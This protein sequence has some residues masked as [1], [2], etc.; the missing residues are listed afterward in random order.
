MTETYLVYHVSW[1]QVHPGSGGGSTGRVH[2]YVKTDFDAGRLKR[3]A[4]TPICNTKGGEFYPRD[5][6]ERGNTSDDMCRTC[7]ERATKYGLTY[8]PL[9]EPD[10]RPTCRL[11]YRRYLTACDC[12][13]LCT[14]GHPLNDHYHCE[15]GCN[16]RYPKP[17]PARDP[18]GF[19]DP[20]AIRRWQ[21][22]AAPRCPCPKATPVE[23]VHV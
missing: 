8:T 9:P 21:D 18:S 7:V 17:E 15:E 3:P 20:A 10:R 4:G 13:Q 19:T 5:A 14:C 11:C 23:V 6:F 12:K 16:F 2:I 1:A 22:E